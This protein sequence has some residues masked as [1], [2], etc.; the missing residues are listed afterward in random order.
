METKPK[1][2]RLLRSLQILQ[3]IFFAT[4]I[5][6]VGRVFFIPLSFSLLISFILY[7]ICS[8]LERKGV[9]RVFAIVLPVFV[10][11][12]L[13]GGISYL[14]IAQLLEFSFEW[15]GI[16]GRLLLAVQD[17]SLFLAEK[18]GLSAEK[19]AVILQDLVDKTGNKAFSLLASTAASFSEGFVFL[20]MVPIFSTLFLLYRSKLANALYQLF[21][22]ESRTAVYDVLIETVH[23]Y[24]GFIKGMATV[25]LIVGIL[26]SIGLALIGVPHP[27]LFGCLA[28]LL[29]FIPYVGIMIGALFPIMVAWVT[30]NSIWYP[31][32]VI[33]VFAFVQ[34]LEAYLIF[35]LS[36]GKRLKINTL[37]VF[38]MI[39]LGGML[40]G[41][42]G[43]ILF[44]PLVSILKLIADKSPRLRYLSELLG[45]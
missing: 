11:I 10:V 30:Y 24:Y 29:T 3:L 34:L 27:V 33:A 41:A 39:V 14:L 1:Q 21:P 22:A 8:W 25:Y 40:W 12:L 35:P 5:L 15:E 9:G 6:Y 7:P 20:V 36:V 28:A 13:L 31:L 18:L 23:A 45:E 2:D 37:T 44:I 26:N 42:A 19:Q 32:A 43:M 17:L 4:L 16:K 38:L